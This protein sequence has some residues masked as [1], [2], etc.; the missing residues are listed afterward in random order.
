MVSSTLSE[1]IHS[2]KGYRTETFS[3]S[4]V[5]NLEEIL[6]FEIS[7][8]GNLDVLDY[9][10]E[11]YGILSDFAIEEEELI[12]LKSIA[13]DENDLKQL[14]MS[15]E[16]QMVMEDP[17]YYIDQVMGFVCEILGKTN[18]TGIWLT[19]RKNVITV[20]NGCP[21]DIDE[22]TLPKKYVVLSDL[23]ADGALFAY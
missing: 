16:Q 13:K 17:H 7:S 14:I 21:D 5:R 4:G 8:L 6:R 1:M 2:G 9:L 23:G 11:N 22:Y 10:K 20:Y 12:N 18:I 3:G 15:E 19:T